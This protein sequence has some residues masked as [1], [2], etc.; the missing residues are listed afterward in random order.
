MCQ[1]ILLEPAQ[2][3]LFDFNNKKELDEWEVLSGEW[4]VKDG[5]LKGGTDSGEGIIL[6]GDAT[7][8]DY[9]VEMKIKSVGQGQFIAY[10]FALRLNAPNQLYTFSMDNGEGKEKA[11]GW[12]NAGG[13]KS[14]GQKEM[15]VKKDTWYIQRA[16]FDGKHFQGWVDGEKV[17]EYDEGTYNQGQVGVRVYSDKVEVDYFKVDGHGIPQSPDSLVQLHGKLSTTWGKIKQR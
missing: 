9:T 16:T 5:V 11:I 2:A 15:K 4:E 6:T 10:G 14:L 13:W 8:G 1:G 3:L 7:W 12:V 17:L